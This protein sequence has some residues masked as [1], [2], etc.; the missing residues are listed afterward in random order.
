MEN[1]ITDE[2]REKLEVIKEK[3]NPK[4]EE[5]PNLINEIYEREKIASLKLRNI[6]LSESELDDS[7]SIMHS[8]RSDKMRESK[9]VI[10]EVIANQ[11]YLEKR[12][13]ELESIKMYL[14]I[15]LN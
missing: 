13:E 9:L 7:L 10:Q 12:K 14:N 2:I 15:N 8:R 3:L 4:V 11:V 1:E 5:L 6:K